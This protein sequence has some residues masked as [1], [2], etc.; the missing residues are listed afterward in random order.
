MTFSASNQ[1][2][3]RS[4]G[5]QDPR[6]TQSLIITKALEVS[7]RVVPHQDRCSN[8]TDPPSNVTFWCALQDATADNGC[9]TVAPGSHIVEP[10]ARRC[11]A[12]DRGLPQFTPVANPRYAK[13]AGSGELVEQ[14]RNADGGYEFKP[15]E[16]KAGTLI[17][18]HGNLADNYLQPYDGETEFEKLEPK[19]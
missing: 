1:Q 9:L 19:S 3:L 7:P 12:G 2:I 15:L 14:K 13:I 18:M 6:V 8:F 10:I 4:L 16:V 11:R 5:Y 17:L